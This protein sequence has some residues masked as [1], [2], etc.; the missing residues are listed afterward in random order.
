MAASLNTLFFFYKIDVGGLV[1][2][3]FSIQRTSIR[4]PQAASTYNVNFSVTYTCECSVLN[5]SLTVKKTFVMKPV[6]EGSQSF[7][8]SKVY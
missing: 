3:C 8:N 4:I 2:G 1:N 6:E 7:E 5:L